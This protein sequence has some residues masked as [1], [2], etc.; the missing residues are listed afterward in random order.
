MRRLII[1][2][3]AI[4]CASQAYGS[5]IRYVDAGKLLSESRP[6]QAAR[7]HLGEARKVLEQGYED[8]GKAWEKSKDK[9]RVLR[10]GL[11]ALNA[12]M[13]AEEQAALG[14]VARI[15]KEEISAWRKANNVD[16]VI[17]R[18]DLLDASEELDVTQAIMESMDRREAAFA[19]LP[20]VTVK[21]P[22][23]AAPAKPAPKKR[24]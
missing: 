5:E 9:D 18:Q 14:V 16:L 1:F 8:L 13:R 21:E 23:P 24:K 17:A 6:A 3:M 4:F 11:E 19:E 2:F 22:E 10:E 12:Q 15:M 7:H 20:K